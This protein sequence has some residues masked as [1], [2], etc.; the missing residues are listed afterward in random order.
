VHRVGIAN[1]RLLDVAGGQVT[2][3]TKGKP[4][5]WEPIIALLRNTT[6]EFC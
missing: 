3:R 6:T 4:L 2:F 1:S 5:P